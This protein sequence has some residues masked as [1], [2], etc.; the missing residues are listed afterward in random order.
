MLLSHIGYCVGWHAKIVLSCF[1]VSD[2]YSSRYFNGERFHH[3]WDGQ[4]PS[5]RAQ[6][7]YQL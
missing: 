4:R 5:G 7:S 3:L 2:N 1:H 6:T